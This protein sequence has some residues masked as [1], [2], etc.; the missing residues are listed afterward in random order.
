MGQEATTDD[1]CCQVRTGGDRQGLGSFC[2]K[3]KN[4]FVLQKTH[5]S[6]EHLAPNTHAAGAGPLALF[7]LDSLDNSSILTVSQSV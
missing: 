3:A 4:G 2:K 1:N 6:V 5:F 7:P